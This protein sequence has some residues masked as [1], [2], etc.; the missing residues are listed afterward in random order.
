MRTQLPAWFQQVAELESRAE[1]IRVLQ[2]QLVH[3]LLRTEAYARAVLS[4]MGDHEL[5]NRTS[6][7]LARQRIFD[8]EEPP[9]FWQVLSEA[10]LHQEVGGK[11]VMWQ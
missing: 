11:E 6:A 4:A 9:V 1:A 7:R 8:K 3:G 5:D 10:V 2:L